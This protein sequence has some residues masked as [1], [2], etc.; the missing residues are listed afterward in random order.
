MSRTRGEPSPDERQ[1]ALPL[2]K[3]P[4]RRAP[5][6]PEQTAKV[7]VAKLTSPVGFPDKAELTLRLSLPRA[8]C[9]RLMARATREGSPELRGVGAG[10]AGAGGE[11]RLNAVLTRRERCGPAG[12][13]LQGTLVERLTHKPP[14]LVAPL[15]VSN[16]R[17]CRSVNVKNGTS[18]AVAISWSGPERA[19]IPSMPMP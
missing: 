7:V 18:A 5:P 1:T 19:L 11:G 8:V 12:L 10:G 16:G 15:L 4:A 13:V 14:Y 9:E 2:A 17:P 6:T 3:A